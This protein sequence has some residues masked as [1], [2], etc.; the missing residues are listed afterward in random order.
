MPEHDALLSIAVD[1]TS[2]L[3]ASDRY[4]RLLDTVRAAIPYDAAAVLRADDGK[5]VVMAV[6]GLSPEILGQ[7]LDPKDHPRLDLI[8]SGAEPVRFPADSPLPDPFDGL[9]LTAPGV[10]GRVHAC[11][12]CPLMQDGKVI[13]VLAIDSV[14]PGAFDALENGFLRMVGALS[15]AAMHTAHLFDVLENDSRRHQRVARDL[16]R[17]AAA[18]FGGGILGTSKAINITRDEIKLVAGT[19]FVVLITGETGVGKELVARAIHDGSARQHEPL[20]HVNCAALPESMAE[21]ELF[22]HV[23]GAFTGAENERA[24]KFE[25]A[26]G[27]TLFLDE[28][29]ELPLSMQAKLLRAIQEG[30]IQRVGSDEALN[31]NVRVLAATNRNLESEVEAGRFRPDL[32]HRLN[33]Y[34]L[35]VLPLRQRREDIPVLASYFL[36]RHRRKLGVEE[37]GLSDEAREAMGNAKWPGNARELDHLLGRALL[38][39]SANSKGGMIVVGCEHLRMVGAAEDVP[40]SPEAIP[41]G[42]AAITVDLPLKDAVEEFK[43]GRIQRAIAS[44]AGN[45]AAA[46]RAL[47]L[48]RSNLHSLM[49]RL[50]LR[51][52]ST[53]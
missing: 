43:R 7:R 15:G 12:G 25:V 19:D 40:C 51:D 21:S 37:A 42:P 13:G 1:L 38:R 23:R 31:V 52:G 14:H 6:C 35:H 4:S 29:G 30:E 44:H 11:L 16:D 10:K 32:Y 39:A 50:G 41:E 22:G 27:G 20:I 45:Q 24:G 26:D 8:V 3:G 17:D 9:L 48:H 28:I 33:M 36:N 2:S 5:L 47:G 18:R 34:P 49:L 53:H 46:A